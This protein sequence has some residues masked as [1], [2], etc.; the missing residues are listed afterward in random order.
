LAEQKETYK[1]SYAHSQED[2]LRFPEQ[3]CRDGNSHVRIRVPAEGM[4]YGWNDAGNRKDYR[5]GESDV[6]VAVKDCYHGRGDVRR[7]FQ[8]GIHL[9]GAREAIE[10]LRH[11]GYI[12]RAPAR[13]GGVYLLVCVVARQPVSKRM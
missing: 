4:S 8:D 6:G 1:R 3:G 11:T 9:E 5:E 13:A 2:I 7:Y 12:R 10:R